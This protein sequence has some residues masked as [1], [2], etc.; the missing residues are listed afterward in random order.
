[1]IKLYK[2]IV[3]SL[4]LISA[5]ASAQNCPKIISAI[6]HGKTIAQVEVPRTAKIDVSG[7]KQSFDI[8]DKTAVLFEGNA[9]LA[10]TFSSGE[11]LKMQSDKI[12]I[13]SCQSDKILPPGHH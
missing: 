7:E 4:I 12:E 1:M 10:V 5:A 11:V 2:Y 3:A 8:E 6:S 13:S 9:K